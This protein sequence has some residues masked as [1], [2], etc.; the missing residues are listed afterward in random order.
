MKLDSHTVSYLF[1]FADMLELGRHVQH[2]PE[3]RDVWL[4]TFQECA[5]RT[6]MPH[7][8][9][10]L[11]HSNDGAW[12]HDLTGEEAEALL[13]TVPEGSTTWCNMW[14]VLMAY[15]QPRTVAYLLRQKQDTLGTLSLSSLSHFT[16]AALE[17]NLMLPPWRSFAESERSL[18]GGSDLSQWLRWLEATEKL[19]IKLGPISLPTGWRR[20]AA[21]R[22]ARHGNRRDIID[23]AKKHL[24]ADVGAWSLFLGWV[25]DGEFQPYEA[26]DTAAATLVTTPAPFPKP[27]RRRWF[28]KLR[29]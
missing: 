25:G 19:R 17:N 14:L 6:V 22:C 2:V 21:E 26:I 10:L 8:M 23:R 9:N 28:A 5:H 15:S 4:R 12:G 13:D 3:L 1:D 11:R 20:Q 18:T 16:I 29:G 27:R 7:E 24:G